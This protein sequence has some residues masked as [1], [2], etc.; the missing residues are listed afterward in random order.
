MCYVQRMTKSFHLD[1]TLIQGP[2]KTLKEIFGT[3]I[4]LNKFT[5]QVLFA[6]AGVLKAYL[7]VGRG[8]LAF[9]VSAS[10]HRV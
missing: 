3:S 4:I 2:G 6:F 8:I 1:S 7:C 9:L 10:K 5:V